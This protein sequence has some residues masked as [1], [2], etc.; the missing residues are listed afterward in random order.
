MQE[1][2][3]SSSKCLSLNSDSLRHIIKHKLR[4]K[5]I[6]SDVSIIEKTILIIKTKNNLFRKAIN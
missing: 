6:D 1:S 2:S 3:Y 5:M 4:Y